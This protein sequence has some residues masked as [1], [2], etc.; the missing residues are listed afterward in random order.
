M[1]KLAKLR[2]LL[3]ERHSVD[4][5]DCGDQL[6]NHETFVQEVAAIVSEPMHAAAGR[7]I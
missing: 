5:V 2:P 3:P 4:D 1:R 7:G 6:G